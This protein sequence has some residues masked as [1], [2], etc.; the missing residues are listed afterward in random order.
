[1]HQPGQS[2]LWTQRAEVLWPHE[3]CVSGGAVCFFLLSLSQGSESN[4]LG[5]QHGWGIWEETYSIQ[6]PTLSAV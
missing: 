4:Y 1:M 3:G 2:L 6:L 5:S